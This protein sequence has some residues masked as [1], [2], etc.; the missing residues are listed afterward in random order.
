VS[1]PPP[2]FHLKRTSGKASV[3]VCVCVC[4]PPASLRLICGNVES[5]EVPTKPFLPPLPSQPTT[6]SARGPQKRRDR[7][8]CRRRSI[9]HLVGGGNRGQFLGGCTGIKK[10]VGLCKAPSGRE[11]RRRALRV[12]LLWDTVSPRPPCASSRTFSSMSRCG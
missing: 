11:G 1:S 12:P 5:R 6:S 4:A 9:I 3:C 8:R 2:P 7:N 10:G